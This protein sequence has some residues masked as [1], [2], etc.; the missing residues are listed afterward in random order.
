LTRS[1]RVAGHGLVTALGAGRE[2]TLAALLGCR[3]GLA[4][5]DRLAPEMYV[6]RVAPE[7]EQPVPEGLGNCDC[8]NHRLAE[9]ALRTDGFAQRV[10]A[11][12]RRYGA[13]RIAVFVGTSTSGI[14]ETEQAYAARAGSNEAL[15]ADFPIRTTHRISALADYVAQSLGLTGTRAATGTACSS[16]AKVFAQ[17]ARA[18][19]ADLCDAVVVGG[20]DTLC[21]TTL[22]GFR[23]LELTAAAHCRPF[24]ADR[25]GM[26]IG[27]AAAFALLERGSHSGDAALLGYGESSDA[28]HMSTPHPEARGA[29]LAL[30]RALTQAGIAP[31]SV[32]YVNA[33]GTA[34][35]LNDRAEDLAI[36]G[37]IGT[38]VPVGATK[39]WTGHTLGAAGAV[40]SVLSVLALEEGLAFGT[41]HTQR[42]DPEV[43][44]RILTD[45]EARPLRHVV[46]NSFGFGGNNCALVFGWDA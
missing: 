5:G 28:H 1:Y 10:E 16:S 20:V 26:A 25:D 40:E 37:E 24:D 23:S 27:E 34:T 41:L 18:L 32:D 21:M 45:T 14:R 13:D 22:H 42:V 46:S 17:A 12:V 9:A 4:A 36:A 38:D 35:R 39:G 6:G 3:G 19:D 8:R 43:Q 44:S 33:H 11:A 29:R 2:A 7:L 31:R 15:P 30:R